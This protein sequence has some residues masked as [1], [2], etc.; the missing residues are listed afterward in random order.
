MHSRS[1][2]PSLPVLVGLLLAA[3]SPRNEGRMSSRN[4]APQV[5][6]DSGGYSPKIPKAVAADRN[7][8]YRQR[9]DAFLAMANLVKGGVKLSVNSGDN[10]GVSDIARSFR[11]T[12]SMTYWIERI[13]KHPKGALVLKNKPGVRAVGGFYQPI[14]FD[15]ATYRALP[16]GTLGRA[17]AKFMDDHGFSPD[18]YEVEK[19]KEGDDVGY[20]LIRMAQS[21]DLWHVLTG[22][23]GSVNGEQGIQAF[24]LAQNQS[25]A[26]I[27]IMAG[28]LVINAFANQ[29]VEL[30]KKLAFMSL[31]FRLGSKADL[32]AAQDWESLMEASLDAIRR[33][34]RITPVTKLNFKPE[35][36]CAQ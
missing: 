34:L 13:R 12:E 32:L 35:E 10:S 24:G 28:D 33:D 4:D 11:N 3:C 31:G 14:N 2:I 20:M 17:Y 1:V 8:R 21:H 6:S 19:A 23:D 9:L 22:F 27:V 5:E 25:P 26:A 29:P 36:D 15:L 16:E 18:F 7:T 30:C